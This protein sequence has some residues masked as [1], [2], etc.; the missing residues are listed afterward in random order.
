MPDPPLLVTC[1]HGG[2]K[3]PKRYRERF[4][5]H[6][7]LL[8]THRG[9]DP[10]TLPLGRAIAKDFG[11]P[12]IFSETSRLLV[13]LNRSARN[14]RAF[15]TIVRDLPREERR[16]IVA[17]FHA[18]HHAAVETALAGLV[19]AQGRVIHLGVHSFTP[20]LNGEVRNAEIGILFDPKRPSELAIAR[21][22]RDALRRDFPEL[23]VRMNYP[24]KGT[25]DGLTTIMRRRF[26]D[27]QYAGIELE[28]NHGP[29]FTD[30][31]LWNRMAKGARI[32][33]REAIG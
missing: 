16:A 14:F 1:E 31:A 33:L 25:S 32:T 3:I 28:L 12:L 18:P 23:R 24:Y 30:R 11:A 20:E 5:P 7:A 4:L 15:S 22:W 8:G 21:R 29:F 10:G 27:R 26:P 2:N 9:W 17:E 13:D 19:A 6:A